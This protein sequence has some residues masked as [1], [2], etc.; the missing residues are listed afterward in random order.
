MASG[1]R[2]TDDIV[3]QKVGVSDEQPRS[4]GHED[5]LRP[6]SELEATLKVQICFSVLNI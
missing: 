6:H 4:K 5:E 3:L 1:E 2:P